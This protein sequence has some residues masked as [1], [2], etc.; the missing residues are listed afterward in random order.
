M[1]PLIICIFQKLINY[2]WIKLVNSLVFKDLFFYNN[3]WFQAKNMI[4]EF[5][6]YNLILDFY[7]FKKTQNIKFN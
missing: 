4:N 7:L 1:G 2:L 5:L 6:L 3:K